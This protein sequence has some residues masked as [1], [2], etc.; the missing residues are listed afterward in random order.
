MRSLFLIIITTAFSLPLIFAQSDIEK[1]DKALEEKIKA[2]K[3]KTYKSP[4]EEKINLENLFG[5]RKY[6]NM[7]DAGKTHREA[8][9]EFK[10][11]NPILSDDHDRIYIFV[12]IEHTHKKDIE[13]VKSFIEGKGGRI[14]SIDTALNCIHCFMPINVIRS[15]VELDAVASIDNPP[16]ISTQ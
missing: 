9:N 7:R 5:L 16:E 8:F 13:N 14:R 11:I 6:E 3:Q 2:Y 15:I 1:H 4:I 12:F 10:K